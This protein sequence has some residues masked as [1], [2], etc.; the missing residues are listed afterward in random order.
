MCM[1][2]SVTL[3]ARAKP[4]LDEGRSDAPAMPRLG[5]LRRGSLREVNEP[6]AVLVWAVL[7]GSA[8]HGEKRSPRLEDAVHFSR[9]KG[10]R[11]IEHEIKSVVCKEEASV[12]PLSLWPRAA[13]NRAVRSGPD[14]LDPKT[15]E[16]S[17]GLL[18]IG[19]LC[20]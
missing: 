14:D 18:E 17:R 16:P 11:T 13:R 3:A 5:P 6:W 9:T 7:L 8:L 15:G 20:L 10:G 2:P 1:S 12:G 4:G 19:I